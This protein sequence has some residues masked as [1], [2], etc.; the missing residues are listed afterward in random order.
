MRAILVTLA[1]CEAAFDQLQDLIPDPIRVAKGEHFVYRYDRDAQTPQ[2]VVVQKLSRIV[3]G[4]R[5]CLVLLEQGLYQELGVM[6]RV[7]DEF[8]EDV[9]FMCEAIRSGELSELQK[10][11]VADFF[12]SEF[13]DERPLAASQRRSRI[14]R[15][16]IHAA[17]ARLPE[18][19][20]NPSD[21]QEI[22]R[23]ITNANSGYVHGTSEHILDMYCG[24]PPRYRVEGMRGTRQQRVLERQAWD[25]SYRGLLTFTAAAGAFGQKR[26]LQELYAHRD[27]LE[28][29]SDRNE[30]GNP[31]QLF[32]NLKRLKT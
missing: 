12:Q 20:L 30:W 29:H 19:P 27:L 25:Y 5:T 9:W 16:K 14:P 18:N 24:D 11:F 1:V 22:A 23:T 17:L 28:A 32:Q 2:V 26:L 15:R 31:D 13:D 10:R 21:A 7:L 6:F 8:Q 3:T 4:L